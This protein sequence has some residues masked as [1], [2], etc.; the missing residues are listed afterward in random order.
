MPQRAKGNIGS[1]GGREQ[2]VRSRWRSSINDQDRLGKAE[3]GGEAEAAEGPRGVDVDVV[4]R[5]CKKRN[6]RLDGVLD[7]RR[8]VPKPPEEAGDLAEDDKDGFIGCGGVW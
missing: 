4:V 8:Y 2:L 7:G 5:M 6:Q 1:H 3:R